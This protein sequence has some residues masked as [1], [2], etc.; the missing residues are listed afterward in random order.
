MLV[1][2]LK[3]LLEPKAE[4]IETTQDLRTRCLDKDMCGL[5]LKGS[6]TSPNYV[7]DAMLKLIAEHPKISFAAVDA[8][9]LFVQHLE[10]Y[11]PELQN[12]QPRFV[13]FKKVSG[14]LDTKGERLKTSIAALPTNG[15]SYGQMSNLVASVVTGAEPMTKISTLPAIKTRTKKLVAEELA[16]RARKLEQQRRAANGDSSDG[17][18]A[19][20]H[21]TG[22]ANDG[23]KEGRKLER[24]KRRQENMKNNPNYR[25]KTPEEKAEMER[26]RRTRMEEESAKWNMAPDDMPEEGASLGDDEDMDD[27]DVDD[28]EDDDQDKDDEDVLDLD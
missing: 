13:M 24:D 6:K 18:A 16:K 19:S 5:L 25:E 22:E 14:S 2:A 21:F 20:G 17:G 11:L 23:S 28:E 8:S 7:K 15:V 9:V 27:Y 10:E 26:Q 12:G 4:K 1:K 3:N